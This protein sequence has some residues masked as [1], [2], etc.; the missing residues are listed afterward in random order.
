MSAWQL[1]LMAL[2]CVESGNNPYAINEGE[3]AIGLYQIRPAYAEDAGFKHED[4]WCP[5]K[6]EMIIAAYM[7]R[8]ATVERLGRSPT[9]EDLARIHN[10]GL[11]GFRKSSTDDHWEKMRARLEGN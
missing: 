6:S 9:I 1:F 7:N 8:Y 4:A 5:F 2:A 11:N 10:G 3:N